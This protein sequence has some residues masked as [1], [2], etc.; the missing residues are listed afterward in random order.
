M[1]LNSNP[2]KIRCCKVGII[3]L[4]ASFFSLLDKM[5]EG[6]DKDEKDE[7]DL[8]KKKDQD[9]QDLISNK[10]SVYTSLENINT[11]EQTDVEP[12]ILY[13]CTRTYCKN[14][15]PYSYM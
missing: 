13:D 8:E 4:E 10:S 14:D 6:E 3:T 2:V 5:E 15:I 7:E 1:F 11:N 12:G 9:H